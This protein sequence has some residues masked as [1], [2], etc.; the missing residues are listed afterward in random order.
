M[1]KIEQLIEAIDILMH[2]DD[3]TFM[4]ER[5]SLLAG[6]IAESLDLPY[7]PRVKQED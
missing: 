2:E 3:S 7:G 1:S 6:E 4:A 5:V